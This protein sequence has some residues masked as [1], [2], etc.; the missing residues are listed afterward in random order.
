MMFGRVVARACLSSFSKAHAQKM[1]LRSGISRA[2]AEASDGGQKSQRRSRRQGEESQNQNQNDLQT[3]GSKDFYKVLNISASATQEEVKKAFNIL[4][5][6]L[7]PDVNPDSED[8]FKLVTEAYEVLSDEKKRAEY[9][10]KMGL[11]EE[12]W[13]KSSEGR[14]W[15]GDHQKRMEEEIRNYKMGAFDSRIDE[16]YY[17][18]QTMK[19]KEQLKKGP[20][21]ER[22]LSDIDLQPGQAK[23]KEKQREQ[24]QKE[25]KVEPVS[26]INDTKY[27]PKLLFDT[28]FKAKY[29]DNPEIQ[30]RAPDSQLEFT[31]KTH[32]QTYARMEDRPRVWGRYDG[33][34]Y[35]FKLADEA[36]EPVPVVGG[37][38]Q[39]FP[40]IALA[41][42][43]IAIHQVLVRSSNDKE[44]SKSRHI[45]SGEGVAHKLSP[46]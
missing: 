42:A 16:K 25:S 22:R 36:K 15:K 10:G 9:D 24:R 35:T 2:F 12:G 44:V 1:A 26:V 11:L 43:L 21:N 13:G 3:K 23:E 8:Q 33:G 6:R 45:T 19:T 31:W 4:V 17:T 38:K 37:L 20:A 29:I 46:V 27:D 32:N 41:L 40:F 5:K 18:D 34:L 30:T 28:Y 7:H 14:L 39:A